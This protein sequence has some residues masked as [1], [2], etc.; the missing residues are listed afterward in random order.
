MDDSILLRDG[1]TRNLS[2][3]TASTTRQII[4]IITHKP[5]KTNEIIAFD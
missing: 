2:M 1:E 5:E 4:Q 3:S